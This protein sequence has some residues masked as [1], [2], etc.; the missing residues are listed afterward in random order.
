[1]ASGLKWT[2]TED[3]I[4]GAGLARDKTKFAEALKLEHAPGT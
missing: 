1:M 4:E 3:Y 2:S